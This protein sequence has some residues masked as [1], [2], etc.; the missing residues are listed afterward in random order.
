MRAMRVDKTCLMVLERTLHLFRDP[1]LLR[2]EHPLYRMICT[3]VEAL[4]SRATVLANAIAKAAPKAALSI[5]ASLG[6][7]GSGSMP[8][9]A[10]PSVMVSVSV[11]GLSA[12]DLARRLRLDQ[13]CIFSRIEN[14]LV[15]LDMRALTDQQVPAVVEALGRIAQQAAHS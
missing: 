13:A 7:L 3:P 5:D 12:A 15:R 10:I 1:E 11:P 14:D 8:T 6:Y 4:R 9:E 2:R